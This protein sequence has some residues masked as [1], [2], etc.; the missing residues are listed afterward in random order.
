MRALTA[1]HRGDYARAEEMARVLVEERTEYRQLLGEALEA[2]GKWDEALAEFRR[3][4]E[5]SD[6]SALDRAL[7]RNSMGDCFRNKGELTEARLCYDEALALLGDARGVHDEG[8]RAEMLVDYGLLEEAAGDRG[9]ALAR[10]TASLDALESARREIPLDPFGA[11]WLGARY[12]VPAVDGV[13]RTT[14]GDREGVYAALAAT[15]RADGPRPARLDGAVADRRQLVGSAE[16]GA[17]RGVDL[18]PSRARRPP[19][20]AGSGAGRR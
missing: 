8:E 4:F 18:G 7:H 2:Q 13:L 16:R 11:A 14:P 15:E 9:A 1:F 5:E 20:G 10:F 19:A 17:A 6:T 3:A 12:V